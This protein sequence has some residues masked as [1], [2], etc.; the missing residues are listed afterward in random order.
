MQNKTLNVFPYVE[1][2]FLKGKNAVIYFKDFIAR[3]ELI[4]KPSNVTD[5]LSYKNWKEVKIEN[6]KE[7]K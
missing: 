5:I 6:K 1:K 7:A 3:V 4:N 2:I